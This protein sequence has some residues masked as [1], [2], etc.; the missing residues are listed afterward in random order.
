MTFD[1]HNGLIGVGDRLSFCDLTDHS[2]AALGKSND[3]RRG[4]GAF[5]VGDNGGFAAFKYCY[6]RVG[7]TKVNTNNFSHN[8]VPPK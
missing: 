8:N 4:S 1:T 5:G 6:A 7:R 2:F 3:G